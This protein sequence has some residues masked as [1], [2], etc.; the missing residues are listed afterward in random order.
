[1]QGVGLLTPFGGQDDAR[2]IRG[3]TMRTD[4]ALRERQ[5]DFAEAFRRCPGPD[6]YQVLAWIHSAVKPEVYLEIGV[7]AG[8]SLM[9]AQAETRCIAI[10]PRPQIGETGVP[11]SVTLCPVTSDDFFRTYAPPDLRVDLAFLDGLH[12][13]E[14]VLLDFL[15]LEQFLKP[16]SVVVMHD[17]LPLDAR[18]ASRER[19]TR[20]WSGDVWKLIPCLVRFR[21]ELTIGIVPTAPTGLAI[22]TG[23]RSSAQPLQSDYNTMMSEFIDEPFQSCEAFCRRF[24]GFVQNE[25]RSIRAYLSARLELPAGDAPSSE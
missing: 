4:R 14:Q 19:R 10:D 5:R 15:N 13:F 16:D 2:T 18:T 17:C 11:A 7:A 22:I 8:Q 6:Y 24:T 20:F 3:Q 1:M 9:L 23:F 25:E 21:P 12:L